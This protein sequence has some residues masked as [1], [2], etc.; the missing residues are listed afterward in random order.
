M[1]EKIDKR[2][3]RLYY[4]EVSVRLYI[5]SVRFCSVLILDWLPVTP[6]DVLA[7]VRET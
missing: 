7:A 5:L 2:G 4:V 6:F 1:L 3:G